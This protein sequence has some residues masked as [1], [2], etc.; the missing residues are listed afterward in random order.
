MKGGG[1]GDGVAV[2]LEGEGASAQEEEARTWAKGR[3]SGRCSNPVLHVPI[4]SIL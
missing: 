2:W 1:G 4:I 3:M